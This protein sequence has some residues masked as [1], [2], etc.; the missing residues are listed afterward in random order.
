[1]AVTG[2]I[3]TMAGRGSARMAA[4]RRARR[5]AISIIMAAGAII[6]IIMAIA[7]AMRGIPAAAMAGIAAKAGAVIAAM[8]GKGSCA[9]CLSKTIAICKGC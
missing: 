9:S 4:G 1:M 2:R 3:F 6:A 7:A 5:T 8:E